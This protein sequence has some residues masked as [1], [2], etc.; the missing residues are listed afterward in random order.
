M[1]TFTV[2]H[3]NEYQRT[4]RQ[5]SLYED[6]KFSS[7]QLA[8][9]IRGVEAVINYPENSKFRCILR[10]Y[11][12]RRLPALDVDT[13]DTVD[14]WLAFDASLEDLFNQGWRVVILNGN[15]QFTQSTN[16]GAA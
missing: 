2:L 6:S 3:L 11:I 14:F 1:N 5:L 15:I 10:T 12:K 7:D 8:D 9:L 16:A 13:D 4:V